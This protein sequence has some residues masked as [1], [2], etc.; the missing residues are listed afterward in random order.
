M[1][2]P[3]D[4]TGDYVDGFGWLEG[5]NAAIVADDVTARLRDAGRVV[6][7]RAVRAQR[8]RVLALQEPRAVPARRTSGSSASTTCASRCSPPRGRWSG[9]RRTSAVGWTT[10]CT[11]WATGASRASA[12]GACRSPSTAAR[13]ATSSRSS[14]PAPSCASVRSIRTLVDALPELHRPWIDDIKITLRVVRRRR[15]RV[16]RGRRLLARRGHHAVL[17]AR[18]LRRSRRL[19]GSASRPS[20]SAR[21]ASRCA[22]GTTRCSS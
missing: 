10:G 13:T 5:R 8:A 19:E 18:L 20:G 11:T 17:D 12:T 2:A 3:L 14:V 21:C 7:R 4:A 6:Q 1:I 16:S 15:Q 22:S 9:N